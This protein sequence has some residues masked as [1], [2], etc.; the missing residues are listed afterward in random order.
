LRPAPADVTQ[1]ENHTSGEGLIGYD[2]H[3]K[4][5]FHLFAGHAVTVNETFA[6]R[7][8]VTVVDPSGPAHQR[9]VDL[10]TGRTVKTPVFDWPELLLGN[11]GPSAP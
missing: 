9:V 1:T 11:G 8:Y 2:T 10:R 3:G 5:R 4:Q 7:A 6:E